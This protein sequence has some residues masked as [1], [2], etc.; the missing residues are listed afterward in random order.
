MPTRLGFRWIAAA[1]CCALA[2][3]LSADDAPKDFRAAKAGITQKMKDRDAGKRIAATRELSAY[4]QVDAAK[5]LMF[6]GLGSK[7]EDV[8]RAAFETLLKFSQ[9][10]PVCDYLHGEVLKELRQKPVE[11]KAAIALAVLLSSDI[12]EIQQ[13]AE[14][15]LGQ[16]ADLPEGTPLLIGLVDELGAQSSAASLSLLVKLG[17]LEQFQKFA[18]RRA[19]AQAL[20]QQRQPAAVT[21]LIKILLRV[22]GETSAEI[23][24]YLTSISGQRF[25][26]ADE[27]QD[28]WR[29]SQDSFDFKAQPPPVTLAQYETKGLGSYY[30]LPL[31]GAKIVF[32]IDASL[33]M[34]GPR[35]EAAKRELIKAIGELPSTAEFNII[36]FSLGVMPW[37]SQL[38]PA[39]KEKKKEAELFVTLLPLGSRTASYD[40]LEQ[41]LL[42]EGE[43][44]YFLTDGEPND[45]KITRPPQIV[46]VISRMNRV[47]R[48]TINAIGVGVG[49]AGGP[50]DSFLS[51]LASGNFGVYRRVDE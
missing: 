23:K 22:H 12:P 48:M 43:A 1:S 37:Q 44:L 46:E 2:I 6:Q 50:F 26:S 3:T 27:W 24:R 42:L 16:V 34:R 18:P 15:T 9:E 39:T 20:A 29:K 14:K 13:S 4:P 33:S 8:R 51:T 17:R 49:P 41:A 28:W 38:V 10:R 40:A 7:H 45:G 31:Y 30:G 47:R 19:L 5:I 35:I 25:E 11:A 21:E 36:A 32:V